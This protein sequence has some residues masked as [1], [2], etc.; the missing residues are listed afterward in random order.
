[1][2]YLHF[3]LGAVLGGE[4]GRRHLRMLLLGE[5]LETFQ[6]LLG[7]KFNITLITI[8]FHP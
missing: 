5:H 4:H 6:V 7:L 3:S 1:M 2:A 8:L